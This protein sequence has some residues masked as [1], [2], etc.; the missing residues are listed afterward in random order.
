MALYRIHIRPKGG[1]KNIKTTF[2]YCYNNNILGVGW[3]VKDLD[4]TTDWNL[5]Y[6]KAK[7]HYKNLSRCKYIKR[8]IK[9]K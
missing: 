6:E 9:K 5:Y 4:N 1:I 8:Y 3:R 2:D 7:S